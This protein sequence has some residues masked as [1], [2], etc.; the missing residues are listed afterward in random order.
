MFVNR[1][2]MRLEDIDL[3]EDNNFMDVK[4]LSCRN[5]INHLPK[6]P[7]EIKYKSKEEQRT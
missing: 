2:L 4:V 1:K 6:K 3:K 5:T 7:N